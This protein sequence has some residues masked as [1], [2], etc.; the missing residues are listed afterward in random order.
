MST[1]EQ[2][3]GLIAAH[4]GYVKGA[5][6]VCYFTLDTFRSLSQCCKLLR[7]LPCVHLLPSHYSDYNHT[8]HY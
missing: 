6:V 3:P 8:L 1:N 4:A 7:N 2:T 5:A